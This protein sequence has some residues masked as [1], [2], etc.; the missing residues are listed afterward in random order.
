MDALNNTQKYAASHRPATRLG[1][2]NSTLLGGDV[3]A[4]VAELKQAS[5]SNLVIM[6]SGELIGA[7]MAADLI[8]ECLLMIHPFV[9]WHRAP[10][11]SWGGRAS[12]RLPRNC[13]ARR[14]LSVHI[15]TRSS[16]T[17]ATRR[18]PEQSTKLMM[19]KA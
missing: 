17:G 6:G 13:L 8:D 1:W 15:P 10:L 7:L 18:H 11:V 4:T 9:L 12:L 5:S 19:T 16:T 3:L 14:S 2:P